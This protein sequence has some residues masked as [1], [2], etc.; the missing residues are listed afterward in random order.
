M[1]H[2][3]WDQMTRRHQRE[4]RE[5]VERLASE[6]ITQTQAARRLNTTLHV[7]NNFI[8]RKGIFWPVIQQGKKQ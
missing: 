5:L 4:R 8:H 7:L 3:T 1:T 2:E 6:R